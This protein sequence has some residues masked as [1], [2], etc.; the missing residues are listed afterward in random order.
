MM[1]STFSVYSKEQL[2]IGFHYPATYLQLAKDTSSLDS[3][4]YFAWWFKD[5]ENSLPDLL[6]IYFELTQVKNVLP[7]ARNG[8]WAACFDL[9]DTTGDPRVLV[10]D[11]GDAHCVE[12]KNFDDWL[13]KA[14]NHCF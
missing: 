11:L 12:L 8:D 1:Q 13:D 7:F 5:A 2:P 4:P 3:I 14:K 9:T 6:D 10:F